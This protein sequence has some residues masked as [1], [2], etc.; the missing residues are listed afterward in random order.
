MTV[1][2]INLRAPRGHVFPLRVYYEDTDSGGVVYYANYLK[3]A[4]RAR[5]ELLRSAGIDHGALLERDGIAFAVRRCDIE[6]LKPAHLDD[7]LEVHSG[8]LQLGGASLRMDQAVT[9]DGDT[10][11]RMKLRLACITATGRPARLPEW[12]RRGLSESPADEQI[13][14]D[15]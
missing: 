13:Y 14:E 4:E 3:F 2:M 9:R 15:A 8:N 11:V 5:T 7:M 10:L 6:Y 12:V 1:E